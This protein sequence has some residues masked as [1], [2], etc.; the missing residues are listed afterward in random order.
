M[1]YLLDT[2]VLLWFDGA[3][4]KLSQPV[5]NILLDEGNELY[6]SHASIWEMQI[7]AQLGKLTLETA[8]KTLID[9]QQQINGLQLLS[10]ESK[11]IYALNQLPFHH[12]D[13]FDRMLISQ[14]MTEKMILLSVDEKI[15]LYKDNIQW[16]W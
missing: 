2:H 10:V 7:K 5:L 3:P 1:R 12:R 13:P 16:L 11:H 6:L 8:L 15:Q 14:A 4:D 9:L